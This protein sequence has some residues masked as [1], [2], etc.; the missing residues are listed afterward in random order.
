MYNSQQ[1]HGGCQH[2]NL[3]AELEVFGYFSEVRWYS[4]PPKN[5]RQVHLHIP[6][7]YTYTG[8]TNASLTPLTTSCDIGRSD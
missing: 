6:L 5:Y 7:S 4:T 2:Q 3:A 8:I 1:Q